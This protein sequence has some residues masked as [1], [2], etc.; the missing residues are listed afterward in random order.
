VQVLRPFRRAW[1]LDLACK[2][3]HKPPLADR[4]VHNPPPKPRLPHH[5][6]PLLSTSGISLRAANTTGP[7]S[8]AKMGR[9]VT[10][11]AL[12]RDSFVWTAGQDGWKRAE[13]VMELAQLFTVMPPPP[14]PAG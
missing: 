14:P 1:V 6:H 9:M 8:K 12:K 7:Y 11:G 3:A 5:P 2:S 13:D 10:E 4:G